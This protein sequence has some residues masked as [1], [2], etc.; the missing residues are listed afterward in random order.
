MGG[1]KHINK[2]EIVDCIKILCNLLRKFVLPYIKLVGKLVTLLSLN[3]VF[4]KR[5][6]F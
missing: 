1:W 4:F 6:R 3:I 5:I 2:K